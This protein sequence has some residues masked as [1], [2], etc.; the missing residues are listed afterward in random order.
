MPQADDWLSSTR[1]HIEISTPF[2]ALLSALGLT[3][4]GTLTSFVVSLVFRPTATVL[5]ESSLPA[6]SALLMA[7]G[8]QVGFGVFLGVYFVATRQW[9]YTRLRQPTGN[10][11]LWVV[12]GNAGLQL[13]VEASSFVLP[14][15]GL[16]LDVLSGTGSLDVDLTTWPVLWPGI[17]AFLYVLPALVEEQFFRGIVQG[18]LSQEFHP[19]SAVVGGA[20]L[21]AG[22]HGLYAIG[23]SPEFLMTY[24]LNLFGQGL[25]FCLVYERTDNLL[26]VALVHAISWTAIDF[27]FFGLL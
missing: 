3:V 18:R 20:A 7:K 19:A 12:L 1:Q 17:F 27:P 26:T 24:L 22:A 25:V 8:S 15:F 21:F 6:V 5:L 2:R 11:L 23:Q 16:S 13:A 4:V 14:F 9:E 10:D